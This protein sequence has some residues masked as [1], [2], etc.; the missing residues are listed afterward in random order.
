MVSANSP[1]FKKLRLS[2]NFSR[3]ASANSPQVQQFLNRL[4]TPPSETM[5]GHYRTIIDG[6]V[7]AGLWTKLDTLFLHIGEHSS[8]STVNLIQNR[9]YQDV[10]NYT[11]GTIT[12]NPITGTPANAGWTASGGPARLIVY[13]N[14]LEATNTKFSQNSMSAFL[15][16]GQNTAVAS[17][18]DIGGIQETMGYDFIYTFHL[19]VRWSDPFYIQ[20]QAN[21]ASA[22]WTSPNTDSRGLHIIQRSASDSLAI[23]KGGV[24]AAMATASFASVAPPDG[25]L[26]HNPQRLSRAWGFGSALTTQER[27]D[28]NSLLSAFVLATTGVAQ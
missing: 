27:S 20:G 1:V 9:F 8:D 5:T 28:L 24:E 21:S 16:C 13:E 18:Q 15:W 22:F 25:F 14:L 23:Y 6:M 12:F 26:I 7:A 19:S 2:C 11:G 4:V 17:L 10:A 3:N